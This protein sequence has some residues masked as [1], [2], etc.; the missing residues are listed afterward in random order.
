MKKYTV[1]VETAKKLK[2][3]LPDDFK[4][5]FLMDYDGNLF[6]QLD[7]PLL[8]FSRWYNFT[9]ENIL[10]FNELPD[11]LLFAPIFEEIYNKLPKSI[12][13]RTK[14]N[15]TYEL[16]LCTIANEIQ[17]GLGYKRVRD[18][19]F[20]R[21]NI[22]LDSEISFFTSSEFHERELATVAALLYM[23]LIDKGYIKN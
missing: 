11:R 6:M 18:T 13:E 19:F 4:S 5:K 22:N 20:A 10:Y 2:D 15:K 1:N 21:M 12:I 8:E 3:Y 9:T 17:T 23:H 7:E 16:E 14:T